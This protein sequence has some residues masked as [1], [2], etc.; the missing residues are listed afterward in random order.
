[1]YVYIYVYIY[2]YICVYVCVRVRVNPSTCGGSVTPHPLLR[3][4]QTTRPPV[5]CRCVSSAQRWRTVEPNG[6]A[7]QHLFP[8]AVL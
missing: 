6:T 7:A 1:M 3:Y 4:S 8:P 2:I 5:F